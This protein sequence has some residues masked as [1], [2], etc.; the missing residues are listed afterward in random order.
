MIKADNQNTD[1]LFKVMQSKLSQ[2]F[3]SMQMY[4]LFNPETE[5]N[6]E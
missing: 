3:Q 5:S 4:L 6:F 1:D 2:A